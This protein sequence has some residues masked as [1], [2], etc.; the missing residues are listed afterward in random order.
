M[1]PF[2][3]EI[4][5]LSKW[6]FCKR[7]AGNHMSTPHTDKHTE[8]VHAQYESVRFEPSLTYALSVCFMFKG[9]SSCNSYGCVNS[10]AFGMWP[11]NIDFIGCE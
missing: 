1:T 10:S 11:N 7:L 8:L 2:L 3:P 4:N 9:E 6:K 5:V